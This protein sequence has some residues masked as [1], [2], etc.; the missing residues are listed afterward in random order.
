MRLAYCSYSN[1]VSS[2]VVL[3]TAL[4][5]EIG[6]E[7]VL[8]LPSDHER[9]RRTDTYRCEEHQERTSKVHRALQRKR[10]LI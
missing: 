4:V 8:M 1:V 7:I 3:F 9:G 10:K 2:G 5:M 6:D